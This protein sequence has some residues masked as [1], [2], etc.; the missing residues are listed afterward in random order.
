MGEEPGQQR[1]GKKRNEKLEEGEGER[2]REETRE[3]KD[4]QRP[5]WGLWVLPVP[6]K[7]QTGGSCHRTGS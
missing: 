5:L 3:T 1:T 7:A 4:T 2:Q 6:G